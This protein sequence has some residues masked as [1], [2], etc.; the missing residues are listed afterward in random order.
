MKLNVSGLGQTPWL[1]IGNPKQPLILVRDNFKEYPFNIQL[2]YIYN[3]GMSRQGY[4]ITMRI[5]YL[6]HAWIEY[7]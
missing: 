2:G 7:H 4:Q 6:R 3:K 1:L 5:D